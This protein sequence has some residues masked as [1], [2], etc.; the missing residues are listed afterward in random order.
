[1]TK[2]I[3]RFLLLWLIILSLVAFY[4]PHAGL[5]FDPFN[6]RTLLPYL[7]IVTMFSVGWMLPVKEVKQVVTQWPVVLG[8]TAVQFVSM[9]LLACLIGQ[10]LGFEGEQLV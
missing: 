6:H 1:M 9:P 7:I 4:W 2:L 5:A 8:G 10:L 3:E